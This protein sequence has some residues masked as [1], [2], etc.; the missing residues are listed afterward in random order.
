MLLSQTIGTILKVI[1]RQVAI[2]A[3]PVEISGYE[4]QCCD[5]TISTFLQE[6]SENEL[7][8][9]LPYVR[10]QGH[11]GR[12]EESQLMQSKSMLVNLLYDLR[13]RLTQKH[14]GYK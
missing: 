10:C 1:L 3:L 9:V 14:I 6:L 5:Y 13:L 8:Q 4:K 2:F 7:Q 11:E 12:E